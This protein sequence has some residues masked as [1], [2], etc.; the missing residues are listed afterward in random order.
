MKSKGFTLIE[1]LVVIAIIGVLATLVMSSLAEARAKA[2]VASI[3]TALHNIQ[4]AAMSYSLDNDTFAGLCNRPNTIIHESILPHIDKLKSIAG[5]NRVRCVVRT[6]NIPSTAA[7]HYVAVDQLAQKN[8]GVAV[9]YD[10]THYGVDI[11]GVMTIDDTYSGALGTTS[12]YIANQRCIDA[13]KRLIPVEVLK[14]ISDYGGQGGN[15]GF[16]NYHQWS[17]TLSATGSRVY[18]TNFN[19]G[20]I[21]RFVPV[22][23]FNTRVRCA[24]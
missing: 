3:K 6:S 8:F 23:A 1:L 11:Q 21:F 18:V 4:V 2:N 16:T 24:A 22:G 7:G 12:W 13:G 20:S 15:L 14:A 9:Y 5:N 17:S 19:G 10:E